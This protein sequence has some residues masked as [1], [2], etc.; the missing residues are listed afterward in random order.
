MDWD[1]IELNWERY[2]KLARE[3]WHK[4]PEDVFR[5]VGGS[6]QR[7]VSAIEHAYEY[8]LEQAEREV[9]H[10]AREAP[11]AGDALAEEFARS[12]SRAAAE[13][14]AIAGSASSRVASRMEQGRHRLADLREQAGARG[15]L[16]LDQALDRARGR[17]RA[18]P[19]AMIALAVGVGLLLGQL[20]TRRR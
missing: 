11:R 17:V 2:K 14:R 10:W 19:A 6:R 18:H 5:S 13:F 4:I 1:T 7:L 9:N 15:E 12:R 3:K 20:M 8:S 16:A